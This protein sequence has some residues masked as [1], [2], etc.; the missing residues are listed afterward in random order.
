M[1]STAIVAL[2]ALVI[3]ALLYAIAR[4]RRRAADRMQQMTAG[5]GFA[6]LHA[7]AALTAKIG[8]L[9]QI[10]GKTSN[11]YELRQVYRRMVT[12]GEVYIFD[13]FDVSDGESS[14]QATQSVAIIS[15]QLNLPH[16]VLSPKSDTGGWASRLADRTITWAVSRYGEQVSFTKYPELE[17]RYVV[18]STEPEHVRRFFAERLIRHLSETRYYAI[19]AKGDAFTFTDMGALTGPKHLKR[20]ALRD[21]VERAMNVFELFQAIGYPAAVADLDNPRR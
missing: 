21:R 14:W 3:F 9:Y 6:P 18:S 5:M 15:S 13:L 19:H 1:N 17:R 11:P 12:G 20:D 10:L 2:A 16:F 4:S 8:G 7:D